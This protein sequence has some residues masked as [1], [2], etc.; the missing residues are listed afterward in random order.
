MSY[1][2]AGFRPIVSKQVLQMID[3]HLP[4]TL[5]SVA[6]PPRYS[7]L[8]D[9]V[10]APQGWALGEFHLNVGVTPFGLPEC[11]L[12]TNGSY[13][14]CGVA[15]DA[16]S[17]GATLKEKIEYVLSDKGSIKFLEL[18]AMPRKGF[19]I[20]HDAA[21]SVFK[22]PAG[23]IVLSCGMHSKEADGKGADGLRWSFYNHSADEVKKAEARMTDIMKTY[24]DLSGPDYTLWMDCLSKYLAPSILIK[25]SGYS[26]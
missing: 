23:H 3:S 6:L 11:R 10:F 14:C 19:W 9:D 18:A 26:L 17:S 1:A 20:V 25:G 12:L 24:P 13:I 5:T 8:K 16:I 2:M 21:F 4:K 22:I 15:I 7:Q